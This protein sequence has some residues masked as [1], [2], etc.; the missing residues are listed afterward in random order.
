MYIPQIAQ[1][2]HEVNQAYCAA[3]GDLSQLPW[4]DAPEWQRTSA[5]NGVRFHLD[6]PGAG[7]EASHQSWLAEK[8]A[9]GWVYGPEKN[10]E[11]KEHP[12]MLPFGELPVEQQAKDF[13]FRAVVHALAPFKVGA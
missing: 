8:E 5:I 2:A 4:K 6:N 13:I 10:A 7:P 9:A 11:T 1:V 12:C 3:I